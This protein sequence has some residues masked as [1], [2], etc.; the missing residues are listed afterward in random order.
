VP[1]EPRLSEQWFLRYPRIEEAKAAVRD[2]HI[3][4]WPEHW[5]KVYLNWLDKIQDWCI[6]RQV[7]W[8]HR[9]PVWYKK[10]ADR[11]DASNRHVSVDGPP[12]PENWE[13]DEDSLDTWASSWLWPFA[14]LGWPEPNEKQTEELEFWYP[15]NDLVTGP[16]IIFFWVARMIVAGLEFMNPGAA[17]EKRIPFRN[18]YFTG[19]IRDKQGRK[20]SKSLGNSPDP[21][22]LIDKYGADG[23]RFGTM[24]SAPQGNDILFDEANVELGR[25][26][27]NKLWNAARFRQMQGPTDENGSIADIIASH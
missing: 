15:T 11:N 21:I 3:R 7:W 17:L 4:F 19:I 1:I 26:F 25:N 16:D 12:D 9:I 13:Q 20:M 18:V 14:T 23:L 8:G 24:N 6:S 10:G 5:S 2:K 27:C 22:D